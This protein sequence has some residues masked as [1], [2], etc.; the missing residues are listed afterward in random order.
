M[1]INVFRRYEKKFLMDAGVMEQLLPLVEE[2]MVPDKFCVGGRTYHICNLYFDTE[3]DDVIRESLQHPYYK[4]KL[5]LRSYGLPQT[6]EDSVFLELK[7][8]VNR[9]VTKRR[10]KLSY[11]QAAAFLREGTVP[12]G[13]EYM[14]RQVLGEIDYYL[15]HKDVTPTTLIS[16]DR[17][18]YFDRADKNFRLTFDSNLR[19]LRGDASFHHGREGELLFPEDFRLME[20]KVSSAYPKWFADLLSEHR[21]FPHSF[22]KYGVAYKTYLKNEVLGREDI[23][24]LGHI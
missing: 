20:V 17:M 19:H 16:Y 22:S 18:A 9:I 15:S 23:S 21:V 1:A 12:P 5:R 13:A 3:Q 10:A 4:E 6:G 14:Q 11:S 7:K 24:V 8:K 2:H